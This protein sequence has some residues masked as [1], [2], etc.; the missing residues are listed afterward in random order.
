MRPDINVGDTLICHETG[1][2]FTAERQGCTF[3]YASNDSGEVFSDEGVDIR[4]KRELLDRTRPVS[5]YLSSDGTHFTGWKENVLGTVV[6]SH[7]MTLTRISYTH[8]R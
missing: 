8:G 6:S 1:K 4:E 3:N 2:Q 7:V 5:G